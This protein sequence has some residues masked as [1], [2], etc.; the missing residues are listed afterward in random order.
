MTEPAPTGV[1]TLVFTD[2]QGSTSLWDHHTEAMRAALDVHNLLMRGLLAEHLGYEVKTEGDAFML[3]FAEPQHAVHFCLRA[4]QSL[5]Q[6]P[7]PPA[8]LTTDDAGEVK[9]GW[10]RL[11]WRG[12]RVRM[13]LHVGLPDC[14]ISDLT[15]RMDYF[16]PMVNRAARVAGAAHG[17]QI[18]CSKDVHQALNL[19]RLGHPLVHDLGEHWLKGLKSPEHLFSIVA[20]PLQNRVFDVVQSLAPPSSRA[21]GDTQNVQSYDPGPDEHF[22]LMTTDRPA[23]DASGKLHG[24]VAA[25][26]A[27]AMVPL[28]LGTL[29]IDESKRAV[30]NVSV[31]D[32]L[33]FSTSEQ[34]PEPQVATEVPPN[35]AEEKVEPAVVPV[36]ERSAR[37]SRRILLAASAVLLVSLAAGGALMMWRRSQS[38]AVTTDYVVHFE[39]KPAG[40]TVTIDGR[41]RGV[42]PLD[43]PNDLPP[44]IYRATLS[45]HGYDKQTSVF[46][47]AATT[48]VKVNLTRSRL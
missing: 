37:S 32:P 26:P 3:A 14:R 21:H 29:E 16:G 7:W 2:V 8:I 28:T 6:A 15:G 25:R 9:D 47:G 43:W 17:G 24:V 44:G 34:T 4:Q 1:V 23:I 12:L 38:A 42:T 30:R 5:L 41:E 19:V 20:E 11:I 35:D 31:Y 33:T 46:Q 39:S 36:E 18:I 48:T 45:L 13:G 22:L 40:A 27:A 10:G